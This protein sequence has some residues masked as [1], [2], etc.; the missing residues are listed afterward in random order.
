MVKC[1]VWDSGTVKSGRL[2]P[3][4]QAICGN[5]QDVEESE[6]SDGMQLTACRNGERK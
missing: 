4:R 6:R 5:C 1:H 3:K 2:I